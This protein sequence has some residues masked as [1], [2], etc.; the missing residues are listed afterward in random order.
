[1]FAITDNILR[2][3]PIS[4]L[5]VYYSK[6]PDNKYNQQR[7]KKKKLLHQQHITLFVE[8]TVNILEDYKHIKVIKHLYT[9]TCKCLA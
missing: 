4:V 7:N 5:L 3:T 1:M 2:E 9:K 6:R 8:I